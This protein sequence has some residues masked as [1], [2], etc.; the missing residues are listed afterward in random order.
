MIPVITF[1]LQT[2]T[3]KATSG[4]MMSHHFVL[5]E[6]LDLDWHWEWEQLLRLV[7]QRRCVWGG[8]CSVMALRGLWTISVPSET[9]VWG[10]G[11]GTSFVEEGL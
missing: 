7:W 1:L 8:R 9:S 10:K 4:V 6:L 2:R 11:T 3:H 5:A